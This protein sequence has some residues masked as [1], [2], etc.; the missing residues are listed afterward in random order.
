MRFSITET[1]RLPLPFFFFA[2]A[3]IPAPNLSTHPAQGHPHL[4]QRGVRGAGSRF[5]RS[6]GQRGPLICGCP[7]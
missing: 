3:R 7:S 2:F 1:S 5:C 4:P 6:P